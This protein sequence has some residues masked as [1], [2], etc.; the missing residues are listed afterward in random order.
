MA[1]RRLWL[2][3]VGLTALAFVPRVAGAEMPHYD[4]GVYC[5]QVAGFGGNFSEFM[6]NACLTQEQAAYNSLK[7]QWDG[8]PAAMRNYC[9][10]VAAFGGAGSFFM[11]NACVEQERK[12]ARA[13]RGFQFQ[14]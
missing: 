14:R 11:L 6:M 3:R 8:L 5:R 2:A 12:A 4:P 7:P 1:G 10:Q 13:N 9:D